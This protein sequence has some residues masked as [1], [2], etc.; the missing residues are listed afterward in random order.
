MKVHSKVLILCLFV[1]F[2]FTR[3]TKPEKK[4]EKKCR[5]I[6]LRGGGTKGAYEVGV[7]KGI[8]KELPP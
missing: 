3:N 4:V 8:I 6:S 2:A 1:A 5:A 7:L